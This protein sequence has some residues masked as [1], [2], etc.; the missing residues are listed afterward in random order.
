MCPV[1]VVEITTYGDVGNTMPFSSKL[2]IFA[3][4]EHPIL[5]SVNTYFY[6]L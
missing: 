3:N 6:E 5:P 1:F 2:R 4:C